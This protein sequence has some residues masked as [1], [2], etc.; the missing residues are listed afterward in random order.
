M[1]I[2]RSLAES[3][4]VP[5]QELADN[6]NVSRY[7]TYLFP[8]PY[9]LDDAVWWIETGSMEDD[10]V[11]QAIDYDGRFVGVVGLKPQVGWRDHIAEI[12]YWVGEPY[13]GRGIGTAAL[14]EMTRQAFSDLDFRKLFAPVLAPNTASMRI[15]EKCGYEREAILRD[16]VRKHGRYYD[17]HQFARGRS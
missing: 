7:L 10:G 16:E 15:L 17:V 9:T 5:L 12:G 14:R 1:I 2:L 8:F 6:E 4:A 11:C 13:W 3:D